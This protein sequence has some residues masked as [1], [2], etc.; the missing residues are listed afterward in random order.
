[1]SAPNIGI[2]IGDPNGIGVEVILKTFADVHMLEC[3]TPVIYA[4]PKFVVSELKKL[5]IQVP[6]QGVQQQPI[7]NK[8]N[9]KQ[10]WNERFVPEYG[11]PTTSAGEIAFKSLK[12]ATN[13]LKSGYIDALVTAPINKATIQ[14]E[15]FKF[16]GHT[17][18]LAQELKGETLMFMINENVR[19]GLITDHVP[20]KDVITQIT[21]DRIIKKVMVMAQS[22]KSDFGIRKP[23]IAVLG[24]NP[25]AGDHGVI[26]KEDEN[27]LRPTL[28]AME[29]DNFMVFGPFSSD[30]FFGSNQYQKYD[31][32][33]AAYHDQGLIPFK[34]LSF[35]LG[36]NFTAGLA[37][38]RTSPDH[39]TA[40][41]IAGKNQADHSSFREAVFA[42]ID[43]LK[44][45][46]DYA[47]MN[48][49]PL[50]IKIRKK[51]RR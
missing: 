45:R 2:S 39:G 28:Q 19:V 27:V 49:N 3:C 44:N 1:M 14:Q 33:L 38:V 4:H 20:V 41:E 37:V 8:L 51:D 35:G 47:E 15:K 42:A 21:P 9:V 26:G 36:V 12:A 11:K 16:P 32:V 29:K 25:H 5:N 10:V 22:L 43:I 50:A 30:S 7:S 23:K 17:D 48:R 24:I 46:A 13:D 31:A 6:V 18:Y 40:Y 34:T